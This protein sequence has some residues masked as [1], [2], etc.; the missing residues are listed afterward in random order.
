MRKYEVFS[1]FDD[2][3]RYCG[4][5][6]TTE[7]PGLNEKIRVATENHP[8]K[9]NAS[10][11]GLGNGAVYICNFEGMEAVYSPRSSKD[12]PRISKEALLR[13]QEQRRKEKAKEATERRIRASKTAT[14]FIREHCQFF[15]RSETFDY[16]Q[17]KQ[18]TLPDHALVTTR[19]AYLEF[20]GYPFN[21]DNERD[22]RLL[23]FP[24]TD[25]QEVV[26]LQFITPSGAK[27]FMNG[28]P[29]A[30]CYWIAYN[31]LRPNGETPLIIIAEGVATLL[32][33]LNHHLEVA[34]TFNGLAVVGLNCGN[35][36]NVAVTL[37]NK[38][39][40]VP[41]LILA[42]KDANGAGLKGAKKAQKL[43]GNCKIE[44]P[45]FT[46]REV[47]FFQEQHQGK[48]PT[49]WNDYFVIKNDMER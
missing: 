8:G 41:I 10:L 45:P 22:Q 1:N 47:K 4:I 32:S 20:F 7:R 29:T 38:S 6:Y 25:G 26:S 40:R 49:D 21:A 34:P 46:S 28:A 27:K 18:I 44:T 35:L 37:R 19:Q 16:C 36:A 17:R 31:A 3:L 48:S 33:V 9:K 15:N 14:D 43:A 11:I 12:R 23:V 2:A 30:G 5:A 24:L 13:A 39:P 42:D